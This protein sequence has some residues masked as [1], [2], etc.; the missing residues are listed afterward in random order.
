VRRRIAFILGVILLA[1]T[2]SIMAIWVALDAMVWAITHPLTVVDII[3]TADGVIGWVLT[4]WPL[5]AIAGCVLVFIG[6]RRR[7]AM[8]G[9]TPRVLHSDVN[10]QED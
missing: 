8:I 10:R 9:S 1:L 2:G 4:Y 3:A 5:L 6:W 7:P